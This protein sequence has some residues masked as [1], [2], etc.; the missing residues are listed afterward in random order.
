M[1]D[2]D[3]LKSVVESL[4]AVTSSVLFPLD[5]ECY[6]IAFELCDGNGKTLDYFTFPIM[7]TNID[8]QENSIVK[9]Q[10]TFGGVSVISSD[11]FNPKKISLKG[12][13]GRNLKLLN[14]G[15][16]GL[17]W[18]TNFS[19][20]NE[21]ERNY[22]QEGSQN[23]ILELSSVIKTGYG[24]TKVLQSI[25]NRSYSV[26]KSTGKVN[27]LYF[28]NLAFGESFLV[29]CE[30][31]KFTQS[32]GSN[33]MMWDYDIN[34]IATCPLHLDRFKGNLANKGKIFGMS[35]IQQS[36]NSLIRSLI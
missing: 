36:T 26:D 18:S 23:N 11:L 1:N 3:K 16:N 34:L 24:C 28:Y 12:N 29:K 2:S 4:G 32:I 17:N 35:V 30:S 6:M 5:F 9:V 8:I 13:F 15:I 10:N 25:L 33:N 19:Q 14:R 21:K 20:R 27:K 22:G 31:V 7:P